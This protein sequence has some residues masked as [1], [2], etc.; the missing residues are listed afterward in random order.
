M[1]GKIEYGFSAEIWKYSS[2][3]GWYFVTLPRKLSKEIRE[4]MQWQEE[5][6]GRLKVIAKI[7]DNEW[8][9]SIWFDK[10]INSYLLPLKAEIRK[11]CNL[12]N[13]KKIQVTI[14]I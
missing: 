8:T 9:T 10:N 14:W 4:N 7:Q 2:P 6:W 11:K 5:G 12:Q 3:G 1:I 13:A